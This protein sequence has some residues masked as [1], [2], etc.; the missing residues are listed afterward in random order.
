MNIV[1]S[2]HSSFSK[3]IKSNSLASSLLT[4]FFFPFAFLYGSVIFFRN[5]FYDKKIFKIYRSTVPT[6][7]IGNIIAGGSGK[8]PVTF[9]FAKALQS[10]ARLA[11]L[12]R[13]YR[14]KAEKKKYPT[15]LSCGKGPLFDSAFVG[16]EPYLLSKKLP[17]ALFVVGA[18][19]VAAATVAEREGAELLI[20][21]DGM[22]H[23]R[24]ARD[25]DVVVVDANNLFGGGHFIP[26]GTLRDSPRSLA[27]ADL[28]V[29]N[30]LK[31]LGRFAFVKAEI[32]RYTQAPVVAVSEVKPK[33]WDFDGVELTLGEGA[34]VALFCG[35][36]NPH[37]F[38]VTVREHLKVESLFTL[39]LADHL[40]PQ[41]QEW[42]AF[43]KKCESS[44]VEAILCTEKDWVKWPG[45]S[46][47]SIA[48]G[49]VEYSLEISCG[50]FLFEQFLSRVK[51][52]IGKC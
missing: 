47:P 44:G 18:D 7:S 46:F 12:S 35:I 26:S 43:I 31:D 39:A 9:L 8:T 13:G 22:Q 51:A 23:R 33:V 48:V 20:L 29:V 4:V 42:E 16:D 25:F 19:R 37:Y 36:A 27:R 40:P 1:S 6:L 38:E 24:L 14:S 45:F 11:L 49:W 30:H 41:R 2:L 21:D 17:S 3:L 5:F 50:H 10:S 32:E 28:I 52:K 15:V 34:R